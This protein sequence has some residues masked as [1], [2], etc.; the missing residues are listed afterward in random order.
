M[1]DKIKLE[2]LINYNNRTMLSVAIMNSLDNKETYG[3][4]PGEP[5]QEIELDFKINGVPTSLKK[6]LNLL[7]KDLER[8]I[9]EAAADLLRK[10][11]GEDVFASIETIK[12]TFRK[13]EI[14][15]FEKHFPNDP[16]FNRTRF[17]EY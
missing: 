3:I 8:Q 9:E 10:R 6:F 17:E 15:L 16:E 7:D 13:F 14:D 11:V 1:T 2:E 4:I 5:N 12:K